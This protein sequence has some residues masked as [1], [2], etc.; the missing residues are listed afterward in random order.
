M[1][2]KSAIPRV[3]KSSEDFVI[4]RL[5]TGESILAIRLKEDEKEITIEYPF[6]LKNYPALAEGFSFLKIPL[7][8][9]VD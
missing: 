1:H 9:C 2:Q 4:V 3:I 5:S 6:A 7:F 8:L